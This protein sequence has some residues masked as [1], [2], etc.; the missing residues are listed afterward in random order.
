MPILDVEFIGP[1]PSEKDRRPIPEECHLASPSTIERR[2][3]HLISICA[4]RGRPVRVGL[5]RALKLAD[6][7]GEPPRRIDDMRPR[8][9][10]NV[11]ATVIALAATI[12]LG[13]THSALEKG[14]FSST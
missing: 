1:V 8:T 5:Q 11:L 12:S 14:V 4:G 13:N 7:F 9:R 2:P 10:R 3:L 6:T